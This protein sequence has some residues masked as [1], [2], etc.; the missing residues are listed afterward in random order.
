MLEKV[1][2]LILDNRDS[3]VIL[4]LS[5]FFT[6]G[7]THLIYHHIENA[8]PLVTDLSPLN[9]QLLSITNKSATISTNSGTENF[10][11]R[12]ICHFGW[13]YKSFRQGS[14]I[15]AMTYRGEAWSLTIG[16]IDVFTYQQRINKVA[17]IREENR[18]FILFAL[19]ISLFFNLLMVIRLFVRKKNYFSSENA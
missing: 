3:G 17:G 6:L 8:P 2:S 12:Y 11:F 1:S 14:K 19:P 13:G 5:I 7:L 16:D 10:S 15:Q 9:G 4:V 18:N